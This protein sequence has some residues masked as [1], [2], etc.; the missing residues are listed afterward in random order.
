[1]SLGDR[2]MF[3]GGKEVRIPGTADLDK[4]Q[5]LARWHSDETN[6][7]RSWSYCNADSDK[8]RESAKAVLAET[9]W[10]QHLEDLAERQK[11]RERV[12]RCAVPKRAGDIA[13]TTDA[14]DATIAKVEKWH[15]DSAKDG[16]ILVLSG[17]TGTGKTCAAARVGW[18]HTNGCGYAPLFIGAAALVA[19]SRYGDERAKYLDAQFLIVDDVGAEYLDGKGSAAADFDELIDRF[20]SDKRHLILTTNCD[21]KVFTE[22]YGARVMDRLAEAGTWIVVAGASRRKRP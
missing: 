13:L 9:G 7:T 1:M 8:E 17:P 15:R 10:A 16:G 12:F 11:R 6:W 4:E 18:L 20:Y 5:W 21:R 22:R 2:I 3:V 14:S 19:L